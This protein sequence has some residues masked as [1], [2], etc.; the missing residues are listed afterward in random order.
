M[1]HM[2]SLIVSLMDHIV[3]FVSLMDYMVSLIVS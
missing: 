3:L 2:V 1:D